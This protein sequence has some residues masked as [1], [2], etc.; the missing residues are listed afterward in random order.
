MYNWSPEASIIWDATDNLNMRVFYRGESSQ[1]SISQLMPVPDNSNPLRVSLGN[2]SLAPYFSHNFNGDFRFNN[3]QKFSSVNIRFNGGM[4]QSPIVNALVTTNGVQHSIPFNGP[5]SYN[6]S[7]NVMTN[8]PIFVQALTLTTA[9]G[10]N[11]SQSTSFTGNN[12]DI[13]KYYKDGSTADFDYSRFLS[14]YSDI[15][16][17][18]DFT[19]NTTTSVNVSERISITYRADDWDFRIGGNTR[20]Q[21]A[22]YTISDDVTNTWNNSVNA[23]FTWNWEAPGL[24]FDTDVRYNWYNGYETNPEST[25]MWNFEIEKFLFNRKGTL[26]VRAYDLLGQT[27]N[28]SYTVNDDYTQESLSNGLGRYIIV[29]FS[30][31]FGNFGGRNGRMSGGNRGGRSGGMG[32]MGGM[33]GGF[34]GPGF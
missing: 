15:S 6:A 1:P 19:R 25:T 18:S 4:V 28:F 23:S 32:G 14:D 11:G 21:R 5:N 34:G 9:T 30:Y 29:A 8:N 13:N 3:R 10:V 20:Y 17:S 26:A 22:W 33:R 7:V 12:I 24:S 27:R 31:R 16:T 2:P